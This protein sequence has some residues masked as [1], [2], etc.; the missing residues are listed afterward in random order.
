[1]YIG[2]NM[3]FSGEKVRVCL[4]LCKIDIIFMLIYSLYLCFLL[5]F[6]SD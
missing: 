3:Y 4:F 6:C 1:M 2:W 5:Y